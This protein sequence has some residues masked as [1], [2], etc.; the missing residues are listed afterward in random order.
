M[1]FTELVDL[2][3]VVKDPFGN[4]GFAGID[5]RDYADIANFFEVR[6]AHRESV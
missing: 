1:D 2:T 5:M 3:A 6:L 4:R